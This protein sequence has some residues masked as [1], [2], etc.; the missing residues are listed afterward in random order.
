ME[1]RERERERET[2]VCLRMRACY[3][4]ISAHSILNRSSFHKGGS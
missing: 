1:E 4:F 2:D 3:I